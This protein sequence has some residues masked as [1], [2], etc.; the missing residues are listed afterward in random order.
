MWNSAFLSSVSLS[1]AILFKSGWMVVLFHHDTWQRNGWTNVDR[2]SFRSLLSCI[3]TVFSF[4]LNKCGKTFPTFIVG[5]NISMSELAGSFWRVGDTSSD[6]GPFTRIRPNGILH[7]KTSSSNSFTAL[8]MSWL[9]MNCVGVDKLCARR[10]I[11]PSTRRIKHRPSGPNLEWLRRLSAHSILHHS[12]FAPSP[13]W[14]ARTPFLEKRDIF[15]QS[16]WCS[17]SQKDH[18]KVTPR[19]FPL[20]SSFP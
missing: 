9:L 19:T 18:Q 10:R 4:R 8:P 2:N 5:V 1:I 11:A 14:T 13:L 7:F 17:V 16:K 6:S 12:W 3:T 20:F 15:P